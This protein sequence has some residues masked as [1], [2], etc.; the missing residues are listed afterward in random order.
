MPGFGERRYVTFLDADLVGSTELD[1]TLGPERAADVKLAFRAIARDEIESQFGT[2][3]T[4]G[5]GVFA[6]FGLTHAPEHAV[7]CAVRAALG[8]VRRLEAHDETMSNLPARPVAR[9]AIHGGLTLIRSD[10]KGIPDYFGTAPD[11][12]SRLQKHAAANQIL[13]SEDAYA[14]VRSLVDAVPLPPLPVRG[15]ADPIVPYVVHGERGIS[16]AG[17]RHAVELADFIGRDGEIAALRAILEEIERDG[18]AGVVQV[19]APAG[20]GKTRVLYELR[21]ILESQQ[22]ATVEI[23]CDP[24]AQGTSLGAF[25]EAFPV[26]PTA[27]A[28]RGAD[29]DGVIATIVA[30][31]RELANPGGTVVLLVDD[32]PFADRT[33]VQ[34][35][36]RLAGGAVP[37]LLL[38]LSCRELLPE[39]SADGVREG[40]SPGT[41]YFQ[42]VRLEPLPRWAA[43]QLSRSVPGGLALSDQELERILD[44]SAGVPLYLEELTRAAGAGAHPD[45]RERS[46]IPISLWPAMEARLAAARSD[47]EALRR[48]AVFEG[49]LP[50]RIAVA[51]T[52]SGNAEIVER[53]QSAG[54]VDARVGAGEV[55]YGFHHELLRRAAYESISPR[56]RTMLHRSTANMLV[57]RFGEYVEAYPHVVARQFALGGEERSAGQ[58]YRLAGELAEGQGAYLVA[59]DHYGQAFELLDTSSDL[60]HP[61]GQRLARLQMVNHGFGDAATVGRTLSRMG[62]RD[63]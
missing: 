15:L 20:M 46:E 32:A 43:V 30:G 24:L 35:L 17:A 52:G 58:Y 4:N 28:G 53:F 14:S 62:V 1:A 16:R 18:G 33:T 61:T 19:V 39:F 22:V 3:K 37:G 48:L 26:H 5:D 47:A 56:D 21:R 55:H 10:E 36:Q 31:L 49:P 38:V 9:I 50:S 63:A 6:E 13:I 57:D 44:R 12:V 25:A 60:F 59:E 54:L 7:L 27:D 8:I 29:A 2:Y 40:V 45:W 11:L 51:L 34:L 42:P 41:K 23:V